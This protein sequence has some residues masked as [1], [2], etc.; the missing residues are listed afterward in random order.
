VKYGP[1]RARDIPSYLSHGSKKDDAMRRVQFRAPDRMAVVPTELVHA[2]PLVLG[3]LLASAL[4]GLPFDAG[5]IGR[6]LAACLP[7][8][9]AVIVGA[10]VFPALLPYIPFRAF[11]L[12]GALLGALWGIAM[13]LIMRASLLGTVALTLMAMPI[14]SFLSMNFTGSS[15]F[16]SQ[17]G[18][19]LEVKRGL[20][21][22]I[23]SVGVGLGLSVAIRI[24]S[25]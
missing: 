18:A 20:I 13:S 10:L 21:P 16:T 7:L 23:S 3:I 4:L 25:L 11:A 6:L 22:V 15:T 24:L 19:A 17:P 14:V 2:W 5:Y 12:K 1:V 8:L 9:G